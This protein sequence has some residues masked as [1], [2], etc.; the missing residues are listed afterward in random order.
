MKGVYIYRVS[1]STRDK[2]F[3]LW[4]LLMV[5]NIKAKKTKFKFKLQLH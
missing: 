3:Y 5:K 2:S 1:E 4:S